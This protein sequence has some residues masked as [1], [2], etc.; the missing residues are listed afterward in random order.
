MGLGSAISGVGVKIDNPLKAA[1]IKKDL[2]KALGYRYFVR[3]WTD[4]NR[5]LFSAIKLEKAAMFIILT[6]IILVACFNI[7]GT[8]IMTVIEKTKDIG[9]LKSIGANRSGIMK[10]FVLQ[11]LL[12][13][14]IGSLIGGICG[15]WLAGALGRYP[16]VEKLGLQEIYYFDRLPVKIEL[17]DF[18]LVI[19]TAVIISLLATLY[20]AWKASR[21]DPVEALRYE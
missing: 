3:T 13:G 10:I 2:Q 11:G 4:M 20:P 21:L 14:A 6:L 5:N 19:G 12:I 16:I 9:I 17:M 1:A 18:T 15:A 7:A 8:L